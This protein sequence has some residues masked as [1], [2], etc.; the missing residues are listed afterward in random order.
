MNFVLTLN[1]EDFKTLLAYYKNVI[2]KAN[3]P[4]QVGVVKTEGLTI[5]FY[6]SKKVM[7][8]GTNAFEHYDYWQTRLGL[9]SPQDDF[10]KVSIGSD[11]SGVGDYF[12]PLTVC[13]AFVDEAIAKK[14]KPLGV[15]DSKSLSDDAIRMLAEKLVI[16]VPYSLLVLPNE[17]YNEQINKGKNAHSLKAHLHAQ[18]HTKLKARV[19]SNVPIII[20]QFCTE[21]VYKNYLKTANFKVFPTIYETKAE[22]KY[23]SVAVASIIARYAYLQAMDKLGKS[24]NTTLLKGA[25]KKVD[26]QAKALVLKHGK[27][28]LNKIA[29]VHFITTKKV[30]D[31]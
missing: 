9:K 10:Y 6:Q 1:D 29:K 18:A 14:L 13:A 3:H 31:F 8:Q 27:S 26:A 4:Y 20:D 21:P 23:A 22:N 25:S 2:E 5:Q 30:L 12:G 17:T 15:K 7:F 11:E 28:I 19:K 16:F 24:L